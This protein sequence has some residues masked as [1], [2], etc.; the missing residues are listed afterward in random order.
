M[1][2]AG[3]SFGLF[4]LIAM[5]GSIL[6][7]ANWVGK[8]VVGKFLP[9]YQGHAFWPLL[10]GIIIYVVLSL[11]PC[12]GD[13]IAILAALVGMGAIWI[14]FRIWKTNRARPVL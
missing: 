8:W 14:A 10:V 5:H 9:T 1:P 3:L 7:I 11:P 4:I 2:I 13:L 6:V 12:L